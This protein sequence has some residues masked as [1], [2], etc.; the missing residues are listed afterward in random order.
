MLLLEQNMENSGVTTP[1]QCDCYNTV[2]LRSN[3][4]YTARVATCTG[5][6]HWDPDSIP[7]FRLAVDDL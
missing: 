5:D 7:K 4:L 2:I 3:T 1:S 6:P